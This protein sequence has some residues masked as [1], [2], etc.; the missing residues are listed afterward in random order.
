MGLCPKLLTV[1]RLTRTNLE[2][3]MKALTSLGVEIILSTR[4]KTTAKSEAKLSL[5]DGRTI[6][7]DLTVRGHTKDL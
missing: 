3:A 5:Q 7:A 1:Q 6:P 4:V 2:T